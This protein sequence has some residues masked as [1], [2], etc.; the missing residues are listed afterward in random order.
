MRR[1]T[2]SKR[3]NVVKNETPPKKPE[4]KKLFAVMCIRNGSKY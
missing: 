1:K 3:D 2:A 4:E